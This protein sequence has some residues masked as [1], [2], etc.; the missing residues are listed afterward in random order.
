MT[1]ACGKDPRA[2]P[3]LGGQHCGFHKVPA[4]QCGGCEGPAAEAIAWWDMEA[5][6][7]WR[8]HQVQVP[9]CLLARVKPALA[10]SPCNLSMQARVQPVSIN[11]NIRKAHRLSMVTLSHV[12][13]NSTWWFY[14]VTQQ[15]GGFRVSLDSPGQHRAS[16]AATLQQWEDQMPGRRCAFAPQKVGQLA[17]PHAHV[18]LVTCIK[19]SL[20]KGVELAMR[21]VALHA[22]R[23]HR[24]QDFTSDTASSDQ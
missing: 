9:A 5:M 20:R 10:S 19:R 2:S 18:I 7:W 17:A 6:G 24:F 16:A 12:S 1:F 8:L 4:L 3:W 15:I 23:Q 22:I 11:L 13:G 14:S 21:E